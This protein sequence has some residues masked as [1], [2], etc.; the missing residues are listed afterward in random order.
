MKIKDMA[1]SRSDCI[2][3]CIPIGKKF[4]KHFD[5]I[6]KRKDCEA[7]NHWCGEMQGWYNTAIGYKLKPY[8]KPILNGDLRDW[9]FTAGANAEDFMTNPDYEEQKAYDDFVTDLLTT[10]NVRKSIQNILGVKFKNTLKGD[11][12]MKRYVKDDYKD[13]AKDNPKIAKQMAKLSYMAKDIIDEVKD[14]KALY[15]EGEQDFDVL[16]NWFVNDIYETLD[17][18]NDAVNIIDMAR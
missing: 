5:K 8:G 11:S 3:K 4:I 14:F 15:E 12:K 13:L 9:F 7:V 2:D 16:L 1:L 17:K 10:K 6:Y 18:M